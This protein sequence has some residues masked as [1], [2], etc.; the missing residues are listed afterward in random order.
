MN[1]EKPE[2]PNG[3]GDLSD[4]KVYTF[5]SMHRSSMDSPARRPLAEAG[6]RMHQLSISGSQKQIGD[7]NNVGYQLA[8][9]SRAGRR[10]TGGG[11][12]IEGSAAGSKNRNDSGKVDAADKAPAGKP[13]APNAKYSK[14]VCIL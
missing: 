12:G 6:A 1:Q 7:R 14:R 4:R 8:E 5:N 3:L 9:G 11:V 10:S 13:L 2:L